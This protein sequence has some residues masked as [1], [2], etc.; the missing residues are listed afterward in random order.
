M[1]F[2]SGPVS[3]I[4][5]LLSYFSVAFELAQEQRAESVLRFAIS[6]VRRVNL[7]KTSWQTFQE[8]LLQCAVAEPGTLQ[9]VLA[10]LRRSQRLGLAIDVGQFQETATQLVNKHLPIGHGSEV[11]WAVWAS[12][13][14]G[15]PLADE[16][17]KLLPM[18][19]DP[20]VPLLALHAAS[21]GLAPRL[22]KAGWNKLVSADELHGPNW[23]LVY[24]GLR[25]K[26]LSL[27]SK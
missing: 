12:V 24:E 25:R 14:L 1:R 19:T 2:R 16:V 18:A 23:L 21:V 5:D 26:W 7:R 6:R 8:L 17:I 20:L 15:V 9:Y 3:Q 22:S 10:T 11:A 13:A 4:N 27:G